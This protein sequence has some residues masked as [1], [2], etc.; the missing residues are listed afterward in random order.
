MWNAI[1][2]GMLIGVPIIF[3]IA[4]IVA[5]YGNRR[6]SF[7]LEDFDEEELEAND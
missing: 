1:F 7:D 6:D 3:A 5:F 2:Y 4:A